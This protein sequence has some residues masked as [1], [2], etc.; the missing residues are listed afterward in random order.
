[1]VNSTIT[2][3]NKLEILPGNV[4]RIP[5]CEPV[6]S[7]TSLSLAANIDCPAS[8]ISLDKAIEA[9]PD[10]RIV[11]VLTPSGVPGTGKFFELPSGPPVDGNVCPC[12]DP[13]DFYKILKDAAEPIDFNQIDDPTQPSGIC[14]GFNFSG[15]VRSQDQ[16]HTA[17]DPELRPNTRPLGGLGF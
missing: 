10:A 8:I 2:I 7:F 14:S 12:P 16:F 1:M 5:G 13:P 11:K 6:T 17:P 15:Q 9:I 4:I 3:K